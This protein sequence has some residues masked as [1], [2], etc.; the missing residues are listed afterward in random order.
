MSKSVRKLVKMPENEDISLELLAE[1]IV[2]L[3]AAGARLRDSRL[4][5]RTVLLL[6]KDMTGIGMKEIE[7]ILDALPKLEAT[8]LKPKNDKAKPL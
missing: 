4:K 7:T 5:K 2:A 6:L 1:S 3:G 8:Y